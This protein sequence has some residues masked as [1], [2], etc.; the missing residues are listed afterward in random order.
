VRRHPARRGRARHRPER[1]GQTPPAAQDGDYHGPGRGGHRARRLADRQ[2]LDP[3]APAG[4]RRP[5]GSGAAWPAPPPLL[6]SP[7]WRMRT[8]GERI[9]AA[10]TAL[11]ERALGSEAGSL[12]VG[13]AFIDG[14]YVP[15]AEA[16]I[17]ILDWGLLRSDCTYDVVYVW[18][19][20][21]FRLDHHLD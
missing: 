10:T 1:A 21:F 19:G 3:P 8:G 5:I 17:P 15:I 9:M 13:A 18:G 6:G 11:E 16:K 20:R 7:L 12:P 14:A 2:R 4:L